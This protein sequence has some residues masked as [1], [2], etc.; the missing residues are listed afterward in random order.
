MSHVMDMSED[1]ENNVVSVSDNENGLGGKG[2]KR[3]SFTYA[4]KYAV[5]DEFTN[6]NVTI[7]ELSRRYK[8]DR[9]SV[10]RWI[11]LENENLP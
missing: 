1:G 6:G 3:R 2:G 7:S 9:K 10:R 4:T 11:N 5:R 8:V